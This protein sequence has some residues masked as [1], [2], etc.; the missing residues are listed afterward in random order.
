MYKN[1]NDDFPENRNVYSDV[2]IPSEMPEN[3]SEAATNL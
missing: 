2:G 3:E 1:K